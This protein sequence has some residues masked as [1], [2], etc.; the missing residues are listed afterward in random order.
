MYGIMYVISYHPDAETSI[1]KIV[2]RNEEKANALIKTLGD[3]YTKDIVS[4]MN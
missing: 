4:E 3:D 1:P 2:V